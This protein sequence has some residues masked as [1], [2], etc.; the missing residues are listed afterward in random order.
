M[1]ERAKKTTR[2]GFPVL[3]LVLLL[4]LANSCSRSGHGGPTLEVDPRDQSCSSDG[5]CTMTM[6]RCSCHC[7]API[8]KLHLNQY[9]DAQEK[10]CAS[11]EGKMCKMSCTEEPRCVEGTCKI[12]GP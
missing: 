7:G 3:P 8:N 5:D 12:I 4:A 2:H 11:Y 10:M 1:N 9:L 6:I